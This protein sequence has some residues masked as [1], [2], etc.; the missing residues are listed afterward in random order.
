VTESSLPYSF[1]L[2]FDIKS[3]EDLV[4]HYADLQ[5]QMALIDAVM[6]SHEIEFTPDEQA[7]IWAETK[8]TAEAVPKFGL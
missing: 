1:D 7:I 3:R 8:E 2:W 6:K 4:R 5:K